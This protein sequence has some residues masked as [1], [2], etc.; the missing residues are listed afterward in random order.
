[1]HCA[2]G[3]QVAV[4]AIAANAVAQLAAYL[5]RVGAHAFGVALAH[6]QVVDQ[7]LAFNGVALIEDVFVDG[8]WGADAAFLGDLL[9]RL[10]SSYSCL[11][12]A[13]AARG[14]ASSRLRVGAIR[15][16]MNLSWFDD[17]RFDLR[18]RRRSVK[19]G[20][21]GRHNRRL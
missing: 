16:S 20:V 19:L 1:M 14:R 4:A 8:A 17:W 15:R 11:E 5:L 7:R 9:Q 21:S 12:A 18:R 6:A 2:L 10:F 3:H 13:W